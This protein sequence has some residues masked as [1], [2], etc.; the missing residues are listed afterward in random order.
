MVVLY[1]PT[2][3]VVISV[4]S[5]QYTQ[6]HILLVL[7]GKEHDFIA[8]QPLTDQ[9]H[10]GNIDAKVHVCIVSA[11]VC[12]RVT[13]MLSFDRF[14]GQ[15]WR[16][17]QMQKMSCCCFEDLLHIYV[18]L[19]FLHCM[20]QTSSVCCFPPVVESC[21]AQLINGPLLFPRLLASSQQEITSSL[22]EDNDTR[23]RL[24]T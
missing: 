5:I 3:P 22:P 20:M 14:R 17:I 18:L 15:I 1:S 13:R 16:Q 10:T 6:S 9:A 23:E 4:C 12:I 21:L 8:V 11:G 24:P 7:P 2:F 19:T